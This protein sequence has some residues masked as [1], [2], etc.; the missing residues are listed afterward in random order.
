M[1]GWTNSVPQ[2]VTWYEN[3]AAKSYG[4]SYTCGGTCTCQGK[5]RGVQRQVPNSDLTQP[6]AQL[7]MDHYRGWHFVGE[8]YE[9]RACTCENHV[10]KVGGGSGFAAGGGGGGR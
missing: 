10:S 7:A 1:C 9:E 2:Q 8:G 3:K 6:W 5:S 4:L